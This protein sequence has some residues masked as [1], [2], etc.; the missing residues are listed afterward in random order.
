MPVSRREPIPDPS[1]TP[2]EDN[3]PYERVGPHVRPVGDGVTSGRATDS[4]DVTPLGSP[5]ARLS[6]VNAIGDRDE[7]TA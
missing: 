3:S 6:V 5:E 2:R 1:P 4:W 7:P